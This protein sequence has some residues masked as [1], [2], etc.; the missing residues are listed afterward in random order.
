MAPTNLILASLSLSLPGRIHLTYL[1]KGAES[2]KFQKIR[3]YPT[4]KD[5]G[6][7]SFPQ[8]LEPRRNTLVETHT[9][10]E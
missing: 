3:D 7:V 9:V 2:A 4:E 1:H 5:C 8:D 6:R 10:T